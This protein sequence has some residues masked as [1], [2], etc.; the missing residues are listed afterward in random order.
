[1]DTTAVYEG[2]GPS[3]D[4]FEPG[5]LVFEESGAGRGRPA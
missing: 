3:S 1:M 2:P 5:V 4:V